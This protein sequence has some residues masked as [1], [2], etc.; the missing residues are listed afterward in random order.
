MAFFQRASLK[1]KPS[2]PSSAP[3]SRR[4]NKDLILSDI[5]RFQKDAENCNKEAQEIFDMLKNVEKDVE[6]VA[7]FAGERKFGVCLD[8][9][10]QN[11]W[12]KAA[13]YFK[14]AQDFY[15]IESRSDDE[16]TRALYA[17]EVYLT[18]KKEE[19]KELERRCAD[20]ID[21]K[22]QNLRKLLPPSK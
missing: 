6:R 10:E 17:I 5:N 18:S 19:G 1:K 3:Q 12:V 11:G 4:D 20:Y 7:F 16:A 9:A 22:D 13:G 14:S 21:E 8:I 2:N 15:L